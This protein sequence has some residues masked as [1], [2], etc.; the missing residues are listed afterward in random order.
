MSLDTPLDDLALTRVDLVEGG[1]RLD[2]GAY[3][4]ALQDSR[5]DD[6]SYHSMVVSD[7]NLTLKSGERETLVWANRLSDGQPVANLPV[8]F[9]TGEN[10]RLG[11]A[12]TDANGIARLQF[13]PPTTSSRYAIVETPFAAVGD[14]WSSGISPYEFGVNQS[15][16]LPTRVVSIYTE[17]AIYRPG[18]TV[19]FKGVVRNDRD[20]HYSLPPAG[21][22]IELI[23]RSPD[24]EEVYRQKVTLSAL[25]TFDGEIVLSENA[26]LGTYYLGDDQGIS[27]P[28]TV[29]AY[30]PPEF[31]VVVTPQSDSLVRGTPAT[32]P[33]DVRYFFG[34]PVAGVPVQWNV[35]AEPYSFCSDWSGSLFLP[36]W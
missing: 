20:V 23:G 15:Y 11:N 27:F 2:P 29:A 24:G 6:W 1:G 21:Q 17:R 36:Q 13:E 22:Q 34:G 7:I 31:E 32:V 18:Q 10:V 33:V 28:F 16:G 30:R 3:L 5:D 26:T 35:L 4:I 25:G 12:T 8:T 19:H 9:Y 14:S